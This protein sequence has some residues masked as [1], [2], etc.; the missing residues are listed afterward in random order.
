MR[1][2][3]LKDAIASVLV[4]AVAIPYVGYLVRGEMPFIQDPRGMAG[5][6]I[7]G[8][9]LSFAAWGIGVHSVFGKVM[10]LVGLAALGIGIAAALVGTEGSELLLAIFMGAIAFVYFAETTYHARFGEPEVRRG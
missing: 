7:V 4:A 3:K 2:L 5:V 10:L 1:G 6:G 8:L 9:I